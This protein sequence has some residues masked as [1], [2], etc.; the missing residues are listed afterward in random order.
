M[1]DLFT[2]KPKK[3]PAEVK[4]DN[5]LIEVQALYDSPHDHCLDFLR[6]RRGD[7]L[8]VYGGMSHRLCWAVHARSKATGCVRRELIA[9]LSH[10]YQ[11]PWFYTDISSESASHLLIGNPTPKDLF[12]VRTSAQDGLVLDVKTDPDTVQSFPIS[13]IEDELYI[14]NAARFRSIEALVRNYQN[15]NV[16]H[17]QHRLK[18]YPPRRGKLIDKIENADTWEID[19]RQI[20]FY[21]KLGHGFFGSVH[22]AKW[23]QLGVAVKILHSKWGMDDAKTQD[24][25]EREFL[26][27]NELDHPHVLK[28]L[29]VCTRESPQYI[30]TEYVSGGSLL[31]CLAGSNTNI[32]AEDVLTSGLEILI[33]VALGMEY[34]QKRGKIHR[35]LA[36]RNILLT[37]DA[38]DRIVAKVADLGLA[39]N[40]PEKYYYSNEFPVCW[41]PPEV[42]HSFK[43]SQSSDSWSFAVVIFELYSRGEHPYRKEFGKVPGAVALSHFLATGKRLARPE[44]CL[45]AVWEQVVMPC[46]RTRWNLRPS[47]SQ[48][49]RIFEDI[50]D[51][52]CTGNWS[53]AF[54][55]VAELPR[56]YWEFDAEETLPTS[57]SF[58]TMFSVLQPSQWNRLP[59]M[60]KISLNEESMA[61]EGADRREVA[62]LKQLRHPNIIAFFGA[63]T[64][65]SPAWLFMECLPKGCKLPQYIDTKIRSQPAEVKTGFLED[66]I[67]QI[68]TGMEYLQMVKRKI[69]LNLACENILIRETPGGPLVKISSF[70][71]ALDIAE[72]RD[73]DSL[74]YT[75]QLIHEFGFRTLWCPPE[76]LKHH[77]ITENFDVW[78]F[79]VVIIEMHRGDRFFT[80]KFLAKYGT[81]EGMIK[82]LDSGQRLKRPADCSVAL[83]NKVVKPCFEYDWRE[84]PNFSEILKTLQGITTPRKALTNEC[85]DS[86]NI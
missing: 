10:T 13:E 67:V 53:L 37:R 82:F 35:D 44:E 54:Q 46:F 65:Q 1:L 56:G 71:F 3:P 69:H 25:F 26:E 40:L 41:S 66:F 19:R 52:Q 15:G 11:E 5:D 6:F 64:A 16:L 14:D 77:L 23:G 17:N 59:V 29:G 49:L 34:L 43:F 22:F 74:P 84:R 45:G 61:D 57:R 78:S 4:N 21:R 31:D 81:H 50:M 24:A 70:H 36:A 76:A 38:N 48:I 72:L 75:I 8:L 79:G 80:R 42:L 33:Q 30:I 68:A 62:T 12:L 73:Q 60:L 58:A 28:L 85:H 86:P 63:S 47:F 39:R 20:I 9:P 83:Y 18:K 32:T 27:L 2:R 7:R 55:S 51:R